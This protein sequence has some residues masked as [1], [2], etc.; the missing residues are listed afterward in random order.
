V[1]RYDFPASKVSNVQPQLEKLIEKNFYLN[2]SAKDAYR[3]RCARSAQHF[4][5]P[6]PMRAALTRST[7]RGVPVRILNAHM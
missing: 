3:C 7:L 5:M 2:K 6:A 1:R 4:R